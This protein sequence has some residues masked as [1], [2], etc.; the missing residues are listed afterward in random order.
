MKSK[1]HGERVLAASAENLRRHLP[2]FFFR[3]DNFAP[4]SDFHP[5]LLDMFWAA[6]DFLDRD[7]AEEDPSHKQ[8]IPYAL[9]LQGHKILI[10]ARG[11]KGG[12][13]K[14]HAKRSVGV[15]GHINPKDVDDLG[16]ALGFEAALRR[17]LQE[18]IGVADEEIVS[19]DFAGLVNEDSAE[20]GRVHL[21]LVYVVRLHP[22]AACKF[23]DC[24]LEAE[25]LTLAELRSAEALA[26]LEGW[27]QLVVAG[28]QP[29]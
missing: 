17:E 25:F 14:L 21:G 16:G 15:G 23:E 13:R 3:A 18:E 27:S 5:P 12:E 28:I 20:V 6:G 2:E 7:L 19:I 29:G 26:S 9:I 11:K 10:Y 4:A 8:L 1:Y 24:L 22:A